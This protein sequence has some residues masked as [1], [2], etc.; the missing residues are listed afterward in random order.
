MTRTNN[1]KHIFPSITYC[2][3]MYEAVTGADALVIMTEWN[4]FKTLDLT[5]AHQLMRQ[6]III[7]ARNIFDPAKLLDAGFICDNIGTSYL[8]QN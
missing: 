7:D 5:R 8:C 2:N 6:P 1:M 3:S 4:E